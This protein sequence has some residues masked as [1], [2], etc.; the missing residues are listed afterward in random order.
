MQELTI[1]RPDDF[2]IHFRKGPMLREVAP[3]TARVFRRALVMP[4]LSGRAVLNAEDVATY[5][6]E[7]FLATSKYDFGA[8]MTMKITD[9]TTPEMVTLCKGPLNVVAGK[10]YPVGVTTN[11]EQGVSN[12]Q[13]LAHKGV[14]R[15]MEECGM[16]LCL[17][18]ETPN[19]TSLDRERAFAIKELP[20][21]ARTYPRLKIVLEHATDRRAVGIALTRPNIAVSITVHHLLLTIDDII[22]GGLD[23]HAFCKPVAKTPEDR[24]FLRKLVAEAPERVFFGSDSAP[25]TV[26]AKTQR[27]AAGI[28]SAPVALP[29]LAQIFEEM[30]AL[31]SLERFVSEN[32]ADFYGLPRNEGTITLVKEPWKVSSF[33]AYGG[34]QPFWSGK[35]ISWKVKSV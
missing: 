10:V 8:L 11:S 31:D 25:H 9:A 26:T 12:F 34:V 2:H 17:H 21:L 7:I 13:A 3:Y 20:W 24:E 35:E 16:V 5:R 30:D 19:D 28:Y 29:L 22:G 32:G 18:G 33:H 1:R 6:S 4:N 14:F 27:G 15:A 23:P